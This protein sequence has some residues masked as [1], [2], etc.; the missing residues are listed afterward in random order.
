MP[1][2][3]SKV[4]AAAYHMENQNVLVCNAIDDDVLPGNKTPQ[5]RAQIFVAA[6]SHLGKAGQQSKPVGDGINHA[7]GNLDVA[8]L[9]G[10]VI[11]DVVK[12][13][14]RLWCNTVCH[15]CVGG[16]SAARRARPRFFTSSASSRMDCSVMLRPSPRA[17]EASAVSMAV[18][19]S[20]RVRSRSSHMARASCTASSSRWSRPLSIAWRTKAFWSGVS[21]TSIAFR[22]AASE[23]AR[24]PPP[25]YPGTTCLLYWSPN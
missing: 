16:Y 13:G 7:V 2:Q 4:A 10:H 9:L 8:A 21:C 23:A 6:A 5:A 24:C 22:V 3:R 25:R 19:I 18:R 1:E 11:P 20:T 17:S 12:L 15:Q 14:F